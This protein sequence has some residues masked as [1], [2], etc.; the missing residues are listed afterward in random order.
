MISTE[1]RT[2][3]QAKSLDEKLIE[4][5]AGFYADPFGFTMYAYPWG[6]G[7]LS[8]HH[9]PRDW[10]AEQLISIGHD[11]E[12]RGFNGVDPV[13]PIQYATAS[14][15]GIGKG[16]QTSFICNWIMS[17]RRFAKGVVT[18]NTGDQLR[19]KTWAEIAKWYKMLVTRHW[20][21]LNTGRTNMN[22][23]HRQ[24]PTE[25]RVDGLA[26]KEEAPEA[27]AGLHAVNSTPFYLLDEASAI[28][29]K[30]WAVSDGGLTD[31]E[32]IRIATGNPTQAAGRF[33]DCFRKHRKRWNCRQIDSRTVEGTNKELL[34]EMLQDFGP[35]SDYARMRV[36]GQFPR[37]SMKQFISHQQVEGAIERA[38]VFEKY[39]PTV[40]GI[41]IAREGDD[42][43]VI[44]TRKGRDGRSIPP[45]AL[46]EKDTMKFG[47]RIIEHIE[48]LNRSGQKV[49][50]VFIDAIGV[51]GPVADYL[52][53]HNYG[54]N[55][56]QVKVGMPH[57]GGR[58]RDIRAYIWDQT[59]NWL[60]GG[61]IPNIQQLTDDL[62]GIEYDHTE[63]TQEL[64]MEKKKLMK[65][66]GLA[67]PDF[68]DSLAL[69]FTETIFSAEQ[70]LEANQHGDGDLDFCVGEYN[71][72]GL[73]DEG[74]A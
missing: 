48:F 28:S 49:D 53:M 12:E 2:P 59:R 5:M 26:W 29:D 34:E 63:K 45:I 39:A 32:P 10:Q 9:G 38:L 18:A 19:T 65:G 64:F 20:F 55:L 11:V 66:R 72:F 7:V 68:G 47:R 21:I 13:K 50:A 1:P 54:D 74:S 60:D 42:L 73:V 15:H 33:A 70:E 24:H 17:T 14:G 3:N 40:L 56:H 71:P 69:T 8:G 67:S 57:P 44:F 36:L 51:G 31:G 22:M 62:T 52:K 61:C 46:D 58:H 43:S 6:T 30:I 4:E 37:F 23:F 27:F 35:D 16:A 25:W 41:D